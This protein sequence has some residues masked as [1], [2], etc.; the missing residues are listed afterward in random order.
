MKYFTKQWYQKSQKA[1][2]FKKSH[3]ECQKVF[4]Q[5]Q[6]HYKKIES[7]LPDII[8][9]INTDNMHDSKIIN[10]KIINGSFKGKDFHMQIDFADSPYSFKEIVFI[11]AEILKIDSY[12]ENAC[13]L[14]HEIYLHRNH[15]EMHIL[16]YSIKNELGEMIIVFDKINLY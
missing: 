6:E 12:L 5:Y 3:M 11:N 10:S 14:Y 1:P 7:Q 13:W 9:F 4:D 15:Y 8:K 2:W 16:F